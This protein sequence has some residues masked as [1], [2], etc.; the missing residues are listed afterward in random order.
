MC[1]KSPELIN[2]SMLRKKRIEIIVNFI[3]N[4]YG[5]K[6]EKHPTRYNINAFQILV[7]AFLSHRSRDENTEKVFFSL[8]KK[9]KT[10][11]EIAKIDLKKLQKILYPIGFYRNKSKRLKQL[12]KILVEK[13]NGKVPKT[14]EELMSLPGVGFKTSAIVLSEA[15]NQ[16][17]IPVDSHVEIISKRLGLVPS[18]Y[19][20]YEV[21]KE[22]ERIIPKSKWYLINLGMIYFGREICLSIYPKCNICPLLKICPYGKN[23]GIK[24]FQVVKMG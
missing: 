20:P 17:Y 8:M 10:P 11:Q 6:I 4:N 14:R 13:Y 5:K 24:R 7:W 2:F 23:Y 9:A 16:N 22:L 19:K 12:C 18:N 3:K 1:L 21:E 15:F